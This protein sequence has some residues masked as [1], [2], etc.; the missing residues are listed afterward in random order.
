MQKTI[1]SL[2]A[3]VNRVITKPPSRPIRLMFFETI[4]LYGLALNRVKENFEAKEIININNLFSSEVWINNGD[5][6]AELEEKYGG[7]SFKFQRVLCEILE[8]YIIDFI[9]INNS[10]KILVIEDSE[11][12]INGFDPIHFIS[13]YMY[14]H[15]LILE[16]EIPVIWMTVGEKEDYSLN[17]Y[18]Y[19]KTDI[20]KGR[21]LTLTQDSFRNCILEY[22]SNY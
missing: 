3:E 21:I 10:K 7:G 16:N 1:N 4:E 19:Y 11:L 12:Y 15:Y 6:L 9:E 8:K 14:D 2:M 20:T 17:E 5:R 13:A 22:K 18:R